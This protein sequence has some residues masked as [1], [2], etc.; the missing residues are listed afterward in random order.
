MWERPVSDASRQNKDGDSSHH[1]RFLT[2]LVQH[3]DQSK[4]SV[5]SPGF[6][7]APSYQRLRESLA[8]VP[9]WDPEDAYFVCVYSFASTTSIYVA[10]EGIEVERAGTAVPFES[11][12]MTNVRD[13]SSRSDSCAQLRLISHND[14]S[15]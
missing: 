5:Y 3:P 10:P 7:T 6:G 8:D 13:C 2:L 12:S 14:T 9:P 11:S 15:S 1:S 4:E